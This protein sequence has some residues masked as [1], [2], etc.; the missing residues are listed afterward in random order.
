MFGW[1]NPHVHE[2]HSIN[3][4][5]AFIALLRCMRSTSSPMR[6]SASAL[7]ISAASQ[8]EELERALTQAGIKSFIWAEKSA[9]A[10]GQ[11]YSTRTAAALYRLAEDA[12][13]LKGI[14]RLEKRYSVAP[15]PDASAPS[16]AERKTRRVPS[17]PAGMAASWRKRAPHMLQIRGG[18]AAC[19]PKRLRGP[20]SEQPLLFEVPEEEKTWKSYDRFPRKKTAAEF[21]GLLKRNGMPTTRRVRLNKSPQLA[22]FTK[23]AR[24]WVLLS[25]DLPASNT[26]MSHPGPDAGDADAYKKPRQLGGLREKEFLALDGREEDR[27]RRSPGAF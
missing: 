12:V 3:R 25:R 26:F 7:E 21:F 8:M 22:G 24:S 20:E 17:P 5:D 16:C 19:R 23:S 1:T 15:H 27:R 18:T 10:R 6:A 2:W 14:E 9:A 4:M 13:F 11:R